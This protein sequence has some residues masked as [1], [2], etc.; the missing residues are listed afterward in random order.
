MTTKRLRNLIE[1]AQADLSWPVKE[2]QGAF[3]P[4][5]I[6]SDVKAREHAI[7]MLPSDADVTPG[8]E[9]VFLHEL[10]HALLCERVHPIFA[11]TFPVAGIDDK[12]FAEIAPALNA[13]GD[14]FVGHWMMEFCHEVAIE[15]LTEE[16]ESTV[17]LLEKVPTPT[18]EDFYLSA[19]IVAQAI[20]YLKEPVDC[21]GILD[22]A[23]KGFLAAPPEKPSAQSYEKLANRL[24]LL[25]STLQCR[26]ASIEGQETLE[27]IEAAG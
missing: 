27:F 4:Y 13:A 25:N 26:I 21:G 24:L 17:A 9:L 12:R 8:H 7:F 11:T 22:E 14:W 5:R 20:T 18:P 1:K 3:G 23:V 6:C 15:D 19:L 10:G 16:Y 2:V